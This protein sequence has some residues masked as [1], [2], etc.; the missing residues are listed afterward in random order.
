MVEELLITTHQNPKVDPTLTIWTWEVSAYLFL[1]GIT[2]GIIFFAAVLILMGREGDYYFTVHKLP[3]WAPIILSV[4]MLMLFLDLEYKVHVWRFYTSFQWT[5]PM[6]WGSWCLLLVY[7]VSILLVLFGLRQGYPR[8]TR[9]LE[10]IPLVTRLIDFAIANKRT[11]AMW[12]V[13][14]AVFLALYT[15]ILLSSFSARPFWN[16]GVLAPLFLA[17]GLS[18][19]AALIVLFARNPHEQHMFVRVDLGLLVVEAALVI[20]FIVNLATGTKVQ[21]EALSLILTGP[22]ALPFWLLFFVPGLVVPIVFEVL[23]LRGRR[24]AWMAVT[25]VLV[26]FGGYMLR[27]VMVRAGQVSAFRSYENLYDP[28]LLGLLMP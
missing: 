16:S 21:L 19:A 10:R 1:G 14:L 7:P 15:G 25:P 13:G 6:S 18:T 11:I 17:S 26:L 3:L 8:L 12:G 9:L 5:S 2:A 28:N 4:G 24:R 22:Y 23:E 20:L 27:D